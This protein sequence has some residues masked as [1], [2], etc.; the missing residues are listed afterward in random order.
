LVWGRLRGVAHAGR[1]GA[2]SAKIVA[3]HL[4]P[5]QL[6]IADVVARGPEDQPIAG[7]AEQARLVDSEI[8]IEPAQPQAL[9]RS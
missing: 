1:D 5:L 4:R 3:L 2:I 9:A 6:R 7:M 8:V